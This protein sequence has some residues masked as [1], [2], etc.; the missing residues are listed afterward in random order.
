MK[1]KITKKTKTIFWIY[2]DDEIWGILPGKILHFFG[3]FEPGE[4]EIDEVTAKELKHELEKYAWEKLLK[5]LAYRERS[6]QEAY[7]GLA[8]YGF[9]DFLIQKLLKKAEN[10]NYLSEE[11]FAELFCESLINKG[12]S[13]REIHAK[14]YEK[15]VDETLIEQV[16][17][18]KY[19]NKKNDEIVTRNLEKASKRYSNLEQKKK[20]EK[21]INYMVRKGFSYHVVV[22]ALQEKGE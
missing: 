8:K 21:I 5:L 1:L 14:M 9:R 16:L 10:Y 13:R 6:R 11:R 4:Y 15:G 2:L 19:S 18:Q 17:A 20:R 7:N 3:Y 22:A 12:K